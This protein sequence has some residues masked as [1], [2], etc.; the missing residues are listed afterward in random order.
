MFTCRSCLLLIVLL[1]LAGA[2]LVPSLTDVDKTC[3][4]DCMSEEVNA[5]KAGCSGMLNGI[6]QFMS[7]L[8]NCT[9]VEHTIKGCTSKCNVKMKCYK[10]CVEDL[11]QQVKANCSMEWIHLMQSQNMSDI[12]EQYKGSAMECASNCNYE[13]DN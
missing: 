9:N 12:C 1:Y 13:P 2:L 7:Q 8:G 10:L 3:Y 4:F 11:S 5:V 6:Q